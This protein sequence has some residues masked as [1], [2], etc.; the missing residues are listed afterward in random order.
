M[1]TKRLSHKQYSSLMS[2]VK[3]ALLTNGG[4]EGLSNLKKESECTK[5]TG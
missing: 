1:C 2:V 3:A 5:C 4:T